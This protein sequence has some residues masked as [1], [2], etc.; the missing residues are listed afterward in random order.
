MAHDDENDCSSMAINFLKGGEI[1]DKIISSG[2]G[3]IE[4]SDDFK[5]FENG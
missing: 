3:D 2:G 1:N 5:K 4:D